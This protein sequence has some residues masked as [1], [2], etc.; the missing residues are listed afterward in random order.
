MPSGDSF[1]NVPVTQPNFNWE[2]TN[3]SQEFGIFRRI[4]T[5]LLVDGPYCELSGKQNVACLKLARYSCIPITWWV[6]PCTYFLT[7]WINLKLILDHNKN[8]IHVWYRIRSTFSD[9]CK[10]QSDFMYKLKDLAKQCEVTNSDEV[11]KFL[12]LIHNK[13]FEVKQ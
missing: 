11:V 10:T 6:C 5:S 7:C 9:C 1:S 13:H 2:A 12:F 4:C 3:L 8:M